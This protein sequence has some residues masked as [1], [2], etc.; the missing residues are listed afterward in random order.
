MSVFAAFSRFVSILG[1]TYKRSMLSLETIDE[2]ELEEQRSLT[3]ILQSA[4]MVQGSKEAHKKIKLQPRG[5]DMQNNNAVSVITGSAAQV[6]K[7]TAEAL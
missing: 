5:I 3:E 6:P 2:K 7:E 1:Y 4:V